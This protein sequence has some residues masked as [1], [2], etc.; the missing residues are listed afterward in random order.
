MASFAE[1]MV[2]AAMLNPATYEEVEHDSSATGQAALVVMFAAIAGAIGASGDGDKAMVVAVL[3]AIGWWLVWAMVTYIIGTAVFKG[4]ATWG[5]LLR[6]LGFAQTPALLNVLGFIPLLGGLIKFVVGIWVLLAVVLAI[7]QAL[8]VDTTKAVLTA[9][10]GLAVV[11][12]FTIALTVAAAV[13]MSIIGL[14]VFW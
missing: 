2:G 11:I 12:G 14:L 8:D 9:L 7:R 4:T 3:S 10:V 1:R 6:T 5:E 13:I